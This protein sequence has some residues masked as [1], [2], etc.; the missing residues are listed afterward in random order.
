M[1]IIEKT[2]LNDEQMDKVTG[3]TMVPRPA[4]AGDSLNSFAAKINAQQNWNVTAEKL[5]AWNNLPADT[6]PNAPLPAN[7]VL[8]VLF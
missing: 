5:I 8:K 6:D 2:A 1:A 3:G 7:T 4:A